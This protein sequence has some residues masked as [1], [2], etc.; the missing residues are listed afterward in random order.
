MLNKKRINSSYPNDIKQASKLI[1]FNPDKIIYYGSASKKSMYLSSG[2]I[3][4]VEP[5]KKNE[6]QSLTKRIQ[7]IIKNIMK[8]HNCFLGDFKSGSD[9]Y[10]NIDI[11]TIKNAHIVGFNKEAVKHA[12]QSK[13]FGNNI[14]KKQ[15]LS[16][17]NKQIG[18]KEWYEISGF[19]HEYQT[20]RWNQQELL[21][22]FK[23][24]RGQKIYLQDTI[25]DKKALTKI[26][27]IQFVDSI[28]RWI[29]ITN[30]FDILNNGEE[31]KNEKYIETLKLNL[32]KYYF[33]EN[34]FK[35]TKRLLAYCLFKKDDNM[36]NKLFSIIN[37]GLGILYQQYSEL[38]AMEYLI[39]KYNVP[40]S[41]L[42]PQLQAIKFRL[43]NVYDF[44]FNEAHIDE[45][46]DTGDIKSV[47]SHLYDC[48]NKYT[49]KKLKELKLLPLSK[50]FYP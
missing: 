35:M 10:Y 19:L 32:L 6:S 33:E 30:Y 5:I 44:D 18:L 20:L 50:T 34:Y 36:S 23:E 17:F 9:P 42:M 48:F 47:I 25:Q 3:D 16:L 45:L 8:T 1:A 21:N 11:G 37:S 12:I 13:D 24:V 29:E 27:I 38:T 41:K 28:N 46:L 14:T 2:D 4:L 7:Q 40:I 15:I 39:E 26:D 22:G 49:Y 31:F 43:G